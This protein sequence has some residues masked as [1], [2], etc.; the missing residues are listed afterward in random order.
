LGRYD[1]QRCHRPQQP[2]EPEVRARRNQR[3]DTADRG[4]REPDQH[5][6]QH[7]VPGD[8]AGDP[9]AEAA[10]APDRTVGDL[11]VEQR[12]RGVADIVGKGA[13]Q[14]LRHREEHEQRDQHAHRANR[15][16]DE[17]VAAAPAAPCKAAAAEQ[18]Q[19]SGDDKR[20]EPHPGLRRSRCTKQR[21]KPTAKADRETL[22]QQVGEAA[23]PACRQPHSG[24]FIDPPAKGDNRRPEQR[25]DQRQ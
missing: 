5:G 15:R 22:N 13:D 16:D 19:R 6:E 17:S 20:A 1:R 21:G 18:Q 9:A 2:V 14:N 10:E 3:E 7:G 8:P 11:V 12:G 23:E 4:R 25:H 24:A